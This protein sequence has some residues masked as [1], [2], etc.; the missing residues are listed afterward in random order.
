MKSLLV[1]C[2]LL[3][4]CTDTIMS[5]DRALDAIGG[6]I[7]QPSSSLTI[8]SRR[9]ELTNTYIIVKDQA[10]S[11]YSCIVNGGNAL[12]LGIINPP[13]CNKL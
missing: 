10:G 7:G 8:E 12:S 4:G 1:A 3:A 2:L 9:T 11:K 6:A 5:N 13:T